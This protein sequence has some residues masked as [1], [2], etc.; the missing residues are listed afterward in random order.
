MTRA[1]RPAELVRRTAQAFGALYGARAPADGLTLVQ[2]AVLDCL[3]R[4]GPQTVVALVKLTGIDRSTMAEMLKRLEKGELLARAE[5]QTEKPGRQPMVVTIT[6]RGRKTLGRSERA[7]WDAE[8]QLLSRLT[9]VERGHFLNALAV[10]AYMT[11][12]P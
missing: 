2:F 3:L 9:P 7:V 10:T 8:K 1:V 5:V 6:P 4:H 12:A 11:V